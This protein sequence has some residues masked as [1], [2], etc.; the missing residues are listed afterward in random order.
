MQVLGYEL[1]AG[2]GRMLGELGAYSGFVLLALVGAL[3]LRNSPRNTLEAEFEA[4]HGLGLLVTSLLIS[5]DS[6][7]VGVA[8][9]AV[10]IPLLPLLIVISTQQRPSPSSVWLLDPVWANGTSAE[11]NAYPALCWS[12]LPRYL[13]VSVSS[14]NHVLASPP[15]SSVG[16]G[17]R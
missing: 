14:K 5:L 16:R 9:P 7:G 10:G 11:P 2:A 1:G 12:C 13:W 15:W 4:T 6:L 3:M 17:R 8:L